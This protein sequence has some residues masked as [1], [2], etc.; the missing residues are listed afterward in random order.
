MTSTQRVTIVTAG[1]LLVF[2][3][4]AVLSLRQVDH[5]RTG[6]SLQ[7][8]LYISSPKVLKRLSLGY[9]GLMADIYWTRAVQY[10][11]GHF[12]V[13]DSQYKLLGPLLDITTYL[14]PHLLVAYEFGANFLS[15]APPNGAGLPQQAIELVE[16][17]IRANPGQWK[18][19]Y[20]MGFIYYLELHDYEKAA[21]AFEQ[22][23]H[24]PDTHPVMRILAA[25]MAQHA[26]N[27]EMAR[28]LWATT[29]ETTPDKQVKLNALAH[30]RAL[31]AESEIAILNQR[32]A[33]FHDRTGRFPESFTELKSAGVL[34][35][36]P[37]DP[38]G[39]PFKL[40]TGGRIEVQHPE[41]LPFLT[42]GLPPGYEP[43]KVTDLKKL[44]PLLSPDRP[45]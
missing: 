21:A 11:G 32:V 20:D 13:G 26:G 4:S 18:L 40:M 28:I 9:D 17:G 12:H 8:V 19:Y 36:I 31:Q 3:L 39:R 42:M 38:N 14:D 29:L 6:S 45:R 23:S 44:E 33:L 7:E 34:A 1:L 24:L 16:H 30:L 2:L 41:D 35:G 27:L 10:F 43:P 22:G 37:V 25:N 15:P 5:L